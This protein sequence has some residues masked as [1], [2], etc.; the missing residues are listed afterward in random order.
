MIPP[1]SMDAFTTAGIASGCK[2]ESE[3]E[4]RIARQVQDGLPII[5]FLRALVAWGS[6]EELLRHDE[7]KGDFFRLW[8]DLQGS[9]GLS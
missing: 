6:D 8:S 7:W 9:P 5:A 4:E 3:S 1:G 2:S